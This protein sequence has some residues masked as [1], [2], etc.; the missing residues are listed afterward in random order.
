MICTGA[1]PS[2]LF[3][4]LRSLVVHAPWLVFVGL[5]FM[6]GSTYSPGFEDTDWSTRR[7]ALLRAIE[8]DV[9]RHQ[10]VLGSSSLSSGVSHAMAT[11]PRHLFVPEQFRTLAYDNNPL[12]IGHQQTI[13]QPT[14][15][16]I[17]TELLAIDPADTVLEVGTGSGYQAAVL[18]EVASQVHTIEI[19][20]ELAVSARNILHDLGY[21]NITVHEGDGYAGLPDCALFDAIMVT[22]APAVL[23]RT[24]LDQ[25][26]PGGRLVA[27]VGPRNATQWL[28]VWIKQ[29]DGSCEIR[30][31]IPV[32][33]VPM[34][35]ESDE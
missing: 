21:S 33:F 15:V 11:V 22:A 31:I 24:L 4:K 35:G 26:K 10:I 23:P 18:A 25:L 17:M 30:R 3:E 27:P 12:P 20:A 8:A 7:L 32:R 6:S 19:I 14:I 1:K 29:D 5:I 2:T 16:A 9:S 28:N 13:S 34:V